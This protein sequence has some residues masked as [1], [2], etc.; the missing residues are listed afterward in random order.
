MMSTDGAKGSTFFSVGE[1]ERSKYCAYA[2]M[3][4]NA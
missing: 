1:R 2:T 3:I 4:V